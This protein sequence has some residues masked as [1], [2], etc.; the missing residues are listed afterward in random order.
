[1]FYIQLISFHLLDGVF[2]RE[3]YSP[4]SLGGIKGIHV[5]EV[6]GLLENN[7]ML[8]MLWACKSKASIV[9]VHD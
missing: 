1:M 6:K 2:L 5:I 3:P 8:G 9:E 7:I 4:L